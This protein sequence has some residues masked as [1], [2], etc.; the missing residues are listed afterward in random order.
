M[1]ITVL[2]CRYYL[3]RWYQR[4]VKQEQRY[5]GWGRTTDSIAAHCCWPSLGD[6]RT[7]PRWRWSR[8]RRHISQRPTGQEWPPGLTACCVS[9][10]GF[11]NSW[12]PV[13]IGGSVSCPRKEAKQRLQ[14]ASIWLVRYVASSDI[15]RN[16]ARARWAQMCGRES[17]VWIVPRL[18]PSVSRW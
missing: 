8:C 13:K 14:C 17:A 10:D 1:I 5:I 16:A 7:E 3:S 2:G 18:Q 4:L 6:C 15:D 11:C 9:V 12:A